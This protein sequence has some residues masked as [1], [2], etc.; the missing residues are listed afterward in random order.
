MPRSHLGTPAA[1]PPP[2]TRTRRRCCLTARCW[3]QGDMIA[4]SVLPPAR[5]CTTQPA[6]LGVP[7]ATSTPDG[8]VHTATWL[9]DGKV[10]V[11]GGQG[12]NAALSSA[13]L[14]DPA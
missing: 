4:V 7:R 13:E 9:P 10:L 5:N 14:Y 11:A 12:N 1:Y 2:A 8:S 3:W 6:G